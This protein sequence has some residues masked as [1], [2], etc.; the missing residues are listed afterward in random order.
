MLKEEA[1]PSM[2]HISGPNPHQT[3]V[4]KT[5]ANSHHL[6]I[7]YPILGSKMIT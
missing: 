2:T 5:K 7:C 6:F 1:R 3:L 4:G